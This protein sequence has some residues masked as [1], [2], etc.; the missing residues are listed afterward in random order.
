[1]A[2][3]TKAQ[4]APLLPRLFPVDCIR[5]LQAQFFDNSAS[6]PKQGQSQF[7][8]KL[9][10]WTDGNIDFQQPH[11]WRVVQLLEP[12]K[13]L[14]WATGKRDAGE[15]TADQFAQY[16]LA[17]EAAARMIEEGSRAWMG[18]IGSPPGKHYFVGQFVLARWEDEDTLRAVVFN[19]DSNILLDGFKKPR[20]RGRIAKANAP[21]LVAL[22]DPN[23][24]LQRQDD[25][26]EANR[27]GR[28]LKEVL[29]DR[30]GVSH[31]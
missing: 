27:T 8:L 5:V 6:P 16:Q 2:S 30:L 25:I 22:Y 31:G 28:T 14:K 20:K 15:M 12:S 19:G 26:D 21:K 9:F 18:H 23:A 7:A 24:A 11:W 10:A 4:K 29:D 1:M 13:V 3:Q 17:Y